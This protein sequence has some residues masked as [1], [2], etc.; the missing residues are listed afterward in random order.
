MIGDIAPEA[1][2][3]CLLVLYFSS[4]KPFLMSYLIFLWMLHWNT[5]N[6]LCCLMALSCK[7]LSSS[8]FTFSNRLQITLA[9]C[10]S[11]WRTFWISVSNIQDSDWTL[12]LSACTEIHIH[13][14]HSEF[15]QFDFYHF[16]TILAQKNLTKV[17]WLSQTWSLFLK[18]PFKG[19][20]IQIHFT[21]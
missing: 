15:F 20:N 7:A 2:A 9:T 14:L 17:N 5:G 19:N 3:C 16:I 6:Y 13:Y 8:L 12:L 21:Q 18:H 11:L 4:D 10:H 1:V